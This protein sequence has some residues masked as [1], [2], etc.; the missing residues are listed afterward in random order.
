MFT[1]SPHLFNHPNHRYNKNRR[2]PVAGTL[3]AAPNAIQ[4][5]AI[6]RLC[7]QMIRPATSAAL[8]FALLLIALIALGVV[9]RFSWANWNENADLHPD[10]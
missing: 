5:G 3:T 6:Y 2:R 1:N 10:E 8:L 9:W 7:T 4:P